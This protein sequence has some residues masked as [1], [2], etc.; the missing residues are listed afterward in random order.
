MIKYGHRET[1]GN[2]IPIMCYFMHIARITEI[3]IPSNNTL[4]L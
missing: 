4:L 2:D 1:D 3:R